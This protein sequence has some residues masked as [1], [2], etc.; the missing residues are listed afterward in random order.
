M[1]DA[2]QNLMLRVQGDNSGADKAVA[3]TTK[4]IQKLNVSGQK[5]GAIFKNFSRS[6][7][8][9]RDASD[10]ASAAADSLGH[11]LGKTLGGAV[12]IGAFKIFSDQI[13]RMGTMLKETATAAQK[14]FDDIEKAGKA[15]SLDEANSQVAQLDGLILSTNNRLREL[16]KS[17]FQ[18]FIAEATGARSEL[19]K[20]V[21]TNQKLRDSKLAEGIVSQNAN[22]EFMSGLSA[23]EKQLQK[24]SDEYRKRN[25][26][27]ETIKDPQAYQAFQEASGDIMVRERNALLDKF[28]KERKAADLKFEKEVYNAEVKLDKDAATRSD[29]LQQEL[30]DRRIANQNSASK[31]EIYDIEEAAKLQAELD[32]TRFDRLMRDAKRVREE[33]KKTTQDEQKYG[34]GLLGASQAGRQ[35]LET[36]QKQ[37]AEKV[38]QE[39]FKTQDIYFSEQA[40]AESARTGTRV[41]AQDMRV[42]EAQRV[43]AAN[44][45]TLAEQAQ[46]QAQGI[47]PEQM[48]IANV[49]QK[50]TG[51]GLLKDLPSQS[52]DWSNGGASKQEGQNVAGGKGGLMETLNSILQSLSSAP[53]VTSG[54]GGSK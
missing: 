54:A 3:G 25:K 14:A 29:K 30:I 49:A 41:T 9:A 13:E 48:A 18:N 10:V 7:S 22:D 46:A 23:E 45:P 15:M 16:N 37:R 53:L 26:I 38:R 20:L 50:Q 8:E 12:A 28:A 47:S 33:Q 27:A 21:E 31:E 11:I 42:R 34:G 24:V 51:G 19:E 35:A 5:A 4:A 44:M 1:A 40:K 32:Q 43:S 39:N 36:A 6:L 17:P 2:T 52:L